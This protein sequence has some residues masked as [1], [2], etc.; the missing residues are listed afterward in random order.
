MSDKKNFSVLGRI[1][2]KF[3][4]EADS[5]SASGKKNEGRGETNYSASKRRKA[6]KGIVAAAAVLVVCL[7]CYFASPLFQSTRKDFASEINAESMANAGDEIGDS[8]DFGN[9]SSPGNSDNAGGDNPAE[10]DGAMGEG[11]GAPEDS[12]NSDSESSDSFS[13]SDEE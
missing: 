5:Y 10:D 4:E 9:V 6:L 2:E 12:E 3:V 11:G 7:S 13:E 8:V 1:D